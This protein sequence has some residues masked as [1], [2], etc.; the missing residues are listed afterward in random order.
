MYKLTFKAISAIKRSRQS[1]SNVSVTPHGN[2][3][4]SSRVRIS[5]VQLREE[6]NSK[7]ANICRKRI[8]KFLNLKWEFFFNWDH[9][10][11]LIRC[12]NIWI[13]SVTVQNYSIIRGDNMTRWLSWMS[14]KFQQ[15]SIHRVLGLGHTQPSHFSHPVTYIVKSI[16]LNN[17]FKWVKAKF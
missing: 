3:T 8:T 16:I 12:F 4:L 9:T 6:G 5:D 10:D 17:W 7:N 14:S 11:V 2:C 15:C 13:L 1:N